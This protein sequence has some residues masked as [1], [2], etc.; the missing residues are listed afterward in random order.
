MVL[1]I[2][3]ALGTTSPFYK[4][5]YVTSREDLLRIKKSWTEQKTQ[6]STAC[7]TPCHMAGNLPMCL[8]P[9]F[10][11]QRV[12][13]A[14]RM[15]ALWQGHNSLPLGPTKSIFQWFASTPFSQLVFGQVCS[16]SH[17]YPCYSTPVS[18][19]VFNSYLQSTS[20][21]RD[22]R[23]IRPCP[24]WAYNWLSGMRQVYKDLWL[25]AVWDE[26]TKQSYKLAVPGI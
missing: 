24:G 21:I 9:D 12:M 6:K 10:P 11:W 18:I 16:P 1:A 15:L 19:R 3:T 5:T 8:R 20:Q 22:V 26:Y 7:S 13:G 2:H 25:Q 23:G 14:A 4:S 17:L